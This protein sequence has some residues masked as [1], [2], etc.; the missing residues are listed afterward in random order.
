[1]LDKSPRDLGREINEGREQDNN[2]LSIVN[3]KKIVKNLKAG[4]EDQFPEEDDDKL[5]VFS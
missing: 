2:Y 1:M 3:D 4:D 5:S